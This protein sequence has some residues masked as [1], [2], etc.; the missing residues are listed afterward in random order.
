MTDFSK[1]IEAMSDDELRS[2]ANQ[3]EIELHKAVELAPQGERH[4]ECFCALHVLCEEMTKR[5]MKPIA[6]GVLQ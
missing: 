2:E 5:G 1:L 4:S 3:C 6:T